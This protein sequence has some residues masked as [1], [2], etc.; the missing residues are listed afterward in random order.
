MF[1]KMALGDVPFV[2]STILNTHAVVFNL[3]L[4]NEKVENIY[5]KRM[6]LI[7]IVTNFL[8]NDTKLENTTAN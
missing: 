1:E 2:A 5:T 7:I 4:K 8:K 6:N 3:P